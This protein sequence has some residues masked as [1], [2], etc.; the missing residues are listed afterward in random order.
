MESIARVRRV[1]NRLSAAVVVVLLFVGV[2][3]VRSVPAQGHPPGQG[4]IEKGLGIS[5]V[6]VDLTGR[7]PVSVAQGSYIVNTGGCNDCH[8]NPEFAPGGNPFL[9]EPEQIN[10]NRFLAGGREFGPF[11]SRNLTPN[12][13]GRPAGL[14][15]EQF[16]I[17]MRTGM[18]FKNR[19]P[20]I[21]PLLQVM[22]WPVIGKH[23]D[24]NLRAI[25]DYLSSIPCLET[26]PGT[27]TP[28]C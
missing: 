24:S 12:R 27:P 11:V 17:S 2:L 14:T 8:T 6:P 15:L 13:S 10:V 21:S 23:T 20:E 18:D 25:Y 1:S 26:T 3:G 5:P 7:N 19:H 28:R 22:P 4:L 16:V 9:G